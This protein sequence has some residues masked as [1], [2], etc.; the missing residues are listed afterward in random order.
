MRPRLLTL[1]AL[2]LL[3]SCSL[4]NAPGEITPGGGGAGGALPA[5]TTTT[6]SSTA[7]GGSGGAGGANGGGGT[8][9][10]VSTSSTGGGPPC[11]SDAECKSLD[12]PSGC[13]VGHCDG[14]GTCTVQPAAAGTAC[15]SL[16][17]DACTQPDTCDGAGQCVANHAADGTECP[18][19]NECTASLGCSA[20]ACSAKDKAF[21]SACG[22][23]PGAGSGTL[24]GCNAGACADCQNLANLRS[25]DNDKLS[26]WS[27]TGGWSIYGAAPPSSVYP[28]VSFDSFVL[29]T[30]GNRVQPY[31]GN[32]AE[33]SSA[34]SPP[35]RI[36]NSLAFRSWNVDEAFDKKTIRLLLQTGQVEVLVDCASPVSGQPQLPFCATVNRLRSAAEWDHVVLDTSRFAGE[37]AQIEFIYDTGDP[38]CG[39][40]QGWFIDDLNFGCACTSDADCTHLISACGDALCNAATGVCEIQPAAPAGTPCGSGASLACTLPDTCTT[41]GRCAHND[42]PNDTPCDCPTKDPCECTDGVCVNCATT[43]SYTFDKPPYP[44][45]SSTPGWGYTSAAAPQLSEADYLNFSSTVFGT[46]GYRVFPYPGAEAEKSSFTT[47]AFVAGDALVFDSWHQDHGY[48]HL[49]R[50]STNGGQTFTDLVNCAT[51]VNANYPFCTEVLNRSADAWDAIS[52]DI[53]AYKGQFITVQ[54]AYE[55]PDTGN[56]TERGWYIDNAK[57]AVTCP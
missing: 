28:A 54:F 23:C 13:A 55:A 43:Y 35:M 37:V 19:P 21:A 53:S 33:T 24:C 31:P 36:T 56:G 6:A 22:G 2:A 44:S 57:F 1:P 8:G 50:L 11:S 7:D 25:F 10:S 39:F 20:G 52:I 29:G 17:A 42:L 46:D 3:A 45:W 26:G 5:A 12:D 16:I 34:L 14:S 18:A 38:C 40:E 48:E 9:A 51:G 41:S 32:H 15:G 4:L 47:Q 30:D 27:L 49:I